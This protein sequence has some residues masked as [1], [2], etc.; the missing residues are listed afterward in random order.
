MKIIDLSMSVFSG[1]PVFPG[2]PAVSV[3]VEKQLFENEYQVSR[4]RFGS[5][6]GTHIDAPRHFLTEGAA[7]SDI[8][9]ECFVGEAIC[10]RPS[11]AKTEVV[12]RPTFDLTD[13]QRESIRPGDR[14]ILSTGWEKLT[15]TPEYFGNYPLFSEDLIMFLLEKQP[16]LLGADLPTLA[17]SGDPFRLHREMFS[18]RTVFVEGLVRTGELREGRFFFS[19]A[20]LK[21]I[22]GDGSPVRAYAI[23]E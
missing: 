12:G 15:G 16:V 11:F 3:T 18:G 17:G 10:L 13:S 2:D 7:V 8:D 5:H 6:T 14:I 23:V 9:L 22:N 1:M 19:A 4:I 21:I 20:P